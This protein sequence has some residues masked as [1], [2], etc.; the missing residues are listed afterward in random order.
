LSVP[1]KSG[2]PAYKHEVKTK[3]G[4]CYVPRGSGPCLP[5]E[6]GFSTAITSRVSETLIKVISNLL[7]ANTILNPKVEFKNQV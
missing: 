5:A 2:T 6:E 4:S 1:Y 3:C 7:G